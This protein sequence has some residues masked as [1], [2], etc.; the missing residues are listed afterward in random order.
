MEIQQI[1]DA[2]AAWAGQKPL[3]KRIFIFGSRVRGDHHNDS[4]LDVAIELDP[5]EY[6]CSDESGGLATWMFETDEWKGEIQALI[7]YEIHLHQFSGDQT[8]T[9]RDGLKRSSKLIYAK[10]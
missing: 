5:A 8:P 4:D 7:P 6:Q 2:I 3:I 9:I 10:E 1:Q